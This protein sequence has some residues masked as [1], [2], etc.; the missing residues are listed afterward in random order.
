M[1]AHSI[2][3]SLPFRLWV[4]FIT[5]ILAMPDNFR[6]GKT[7]AVLTVLLSVWYLLAER[8]R[9]RGPAWLLPESLKSEGGSL[10]V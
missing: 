8:R 2:R 10:K 3:T 5:A 1:G 4:V 7:M 6:A 9:F